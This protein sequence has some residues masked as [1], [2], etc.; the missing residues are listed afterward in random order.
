MKLQLMKNDKFIMKRFLLFS[1]LIALF[2]FLIFSCSS[3]PKKAAEIFTE[4]I[5]AANQLN[6]ANQT[7]NQGRYEDALLILN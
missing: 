1:L 3:A 6:L 2:S 4:R 7:A 5:I